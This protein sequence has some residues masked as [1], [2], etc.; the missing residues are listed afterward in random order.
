ML[1]GERRGVWY[2]FSVAGGGT[3]QTLQFNFTPNNVINHDWMLYAI[4]TVWNNNP[5]HTYPTVNNYC[6]LL[7]SPSSFPLVVCNASLYSPTGCNTLAG[8]V[9]MPPTA[10][11]S[12]YSSTPSSF[13]CHGRSPAVFIPANETVTFLLSY[14]HAV[15]LFESGYTLDWMGS[16]ISSNA[17]TAT[18][19]NQVITP[20]STW[21]GVSN[22]QAWVPNCFIPDCSTHPIPAF[23]APG[24]VQPIIN[25]NVSVKDLTIINGAILTVGAGYT[26]TICGNLTNNGTL[27]CQTG[28]TVKFVGSTNTTINGSFAPSGNCFY[29]VEFAKS[30]GSSVTL[31]TN[32]FILGN[33][34]IYSG[35]VNNNSKITEVGGNFYN[36]NGST[37]YIGVGTGAAGALLAFTCLNN[38]NVPQLFRNDGSALTLNNVTMKQVVASKLT[39]NTGTFSDMV[40]GTG[41]TLTLTQ[42]RIITTA[43]REVNVTNSASTACTPGNSVS[44]V[45]GNLRR[46]IAAAATSYDFPLGDGTS[47]LAPGVVGY[48]RANVN[49][50]AAP[51]AAFTLL[52]TFY[53]WSLGGVA[54]P[55]NGPVASECVTATY[56]ALPTFNHGYWRIDAGGTASGTYRITLYNSGM[57]NNTGS[58]WTAVKAPSGT[59]A[60][61]LSGTCYVP[62]TAILTRRDNLTGFSDFATVQS[63]TPLPIELLSFEATAD[64]EDVACKWSTATEINNDYFLLERSFDHESF[65]PIVKVNGFGAGVSNQVLSYR[66]IDEGI[67][68]GVVYY[69]LKQVDLDG[70]FNYSNTVAVK[71]SDDNNGFALFPNPVNDKLI[72]QNLQ[73][74]HGPILFISVY[75]RLGKKVLEE[76]LTRSHHEH[77]Q[78]SEVD[79]QSL[80]AGLYLLE[81][82][83]AESVFRGRFEKR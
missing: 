3:G 60:F 38:G 44:Y 76:D 9:N 35:I 64:G 36:Y 61:A 66:H 7:N 5:N 54:F 46:A 43:T 30:A 56:S 49:F 78:S 6:S 62:S 52:G 71:C 42:G 19:L 8:T 32:I 1:W 80:A 13:C 73:P 57:S 15:N 28:S 45:E 75:N 34:S 33:D 58:G 11:P 70:M 10:G 83:T 37:S 68:S 14:N 79:V 21:N 53:R 82:V 16:A 67:C 31:N 20:S 26:L 24:G 65:S 47:S 81:A 40:L 4:D 41:G 22:A 27:V 39:L 25:A 29:N 77:S 18:W 72:V 2:T 51:S 69:R 63:Q 12:V 55:G 59:G 48:E 23:I 50:T 17:P 74:S